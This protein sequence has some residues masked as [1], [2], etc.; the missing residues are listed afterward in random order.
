MR[1]RK[2]AS[3]DVDV[4][5]SFSVEE[6]GESE[7]YYVGLVGGILKFFMTM[8]AGLLVLATQTEQQA[9][10]HIFMLV[11]FYVAGWVMTREAGMKT[12]ATYDSV[13]DQLAYGLTIGFLVRIVETV[14]LQ[15]SAGLST[16]DIL[17]PFEPLL[18]NDSLVVNGFALTVIGLVFAAVAEEMLYRGGMVYLG[19]ILADRRAMPETAARG[20]ALVVQAALFSILHSA[21]YHHPEEFVALF[22]GGIVLGLALY[23]KK[24]LSVCIVAHLTV[25]LSALTPFAIQWMIQEPLALVLA[26]AGVGALL[27]LFS[28]RGGL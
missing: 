5:R 20:T 6:E 16:L 11:I 15:W 9:S 21:A 27:L 13:L 8:M 12:L 19:N 22:A 26:V 18:L 4:T 10:L 25:N 3:Q 24:D 23:W 7:G 28:L 17:S 2:R 14:V 1:R